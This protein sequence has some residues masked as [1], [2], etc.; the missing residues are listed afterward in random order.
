LDV[1]VVV[2]G[3][4]LGMQVTEWQSEQ[5]GRNQAQSYLENL[6]QNLLQ[7]I[8][9]HEQR[10][11]SVESVL[12]EIS[13]LSNDLSN[14]NNRPIIDIPSL[15]LSTYRVRLETATIES[16]KSTGTLDLINNKIIT[17]ELLKY[18]SEV[19]TSE[20]SWH[21]TMAE[22][23]RTQFGPYIMKK[24]SIDYFLPFYQYDNNENLLTTGKL[25]KDIFLINAIQ[26]RQIAL[27]SMRA[28]SLD[29]ISRASKI[30]EEIKKTLNN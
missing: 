20:A 30:T 6:N 17:E 14:N 13:S 25:R 2:V 11:E 29:A 5:K 1:I 21:N 19:G 12:N 8:D 4:F 9:F 28:I 7:D 23:G 24:Y 16:L 27:T 10:I 18:Y 22:Y 15:F 3:I 26:F